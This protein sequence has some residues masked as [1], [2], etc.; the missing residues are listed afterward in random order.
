MRSPIQNRQAG[1]FLV[2]PNAIDKLLKRCYNEHKIECSLNDLN[3]R[4]S[5]AER[6]HVVRLV[7]ESAYGTGRC[8]GDS[9]KKY[10]RV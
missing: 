1:G 5:D 2:S 6:I 3:E 9:G 8:A 4:K 10:S 7:N